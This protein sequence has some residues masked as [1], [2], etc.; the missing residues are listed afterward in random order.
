MKWKQQENVYVEKVFL[1]YIPDRLLE[2]LSLLLGSLEGV[3]EKPVEL[4]DK[5]FRL[6]P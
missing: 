1:P 6:E 3:A 2:Y 4:M 5:L